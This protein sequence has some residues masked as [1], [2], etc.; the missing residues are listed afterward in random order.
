MRGLGLVLYGSE[1]VGKTSVALQFGRQGPLTCISCKESGYDDLDAMAEV[2]DNC[3][4]HNAENWEDVV[5]ITKSSPGTL[6]LDSLSGLQAML[7]DYVCRTQYNSIWDGKNGFSS[8]YKGQ[9]VD[10]PPVLME[11]VDLLDRKRSKGE[12]VILIGHMVTAT[13]PNTLGADF[14]SHVLDM[15]QGDKGGLRSV[16]MKW[17]QAVLF[18]NIDV[19]IERN[20]DVDK[21]QVMR[22]K[23][24]DSDTRVIYTTKSPGHSAKNRLNLP[25]LIMMGESP[26]EAFNNLW[27]NI[28]AAFKRQEV[29]V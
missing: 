12:H 23:A 25:P 7:F 19:S 22:G 4:N 11:Y 26:V 2:P 1:G 5:T 18:M 24:R 27:S 8:Y 16:I 15:D 29:K 20:I 28:P 10:S 17:A 14:Q 6:V 3:I 9:R 13:L 21:G